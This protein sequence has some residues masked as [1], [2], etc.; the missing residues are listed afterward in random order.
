MKDEEYD[1]WESDSDGIPV[2]LPLPGAPPIT[3]EQ[4]TR[5]IEVS[6]AMLRRAQARFEAGLSELAHEEARRMTALA[7][8][9][10]LNGRNQG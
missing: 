2:F 4:F 10:L 1:P 3:R 5:K 9:V 8:E 6:D 7:R